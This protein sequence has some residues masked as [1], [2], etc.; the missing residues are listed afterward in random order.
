GPAA[1]A[2]GAALARAGA[3]DVDAVGAQDV[4]RRRSGAALL[5]GAGREILAAAAAAVREIRG[6]DGTEEA[7]H[8]TLRGTGADVVEAWRVVVALVRLAA[9]HANP[10]AVGAA[11][12]RI[13]VVARV[14]D[15]LVA[16]R[17]LERGDSAAELI[18]L[19]FG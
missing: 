11:F 12:L 14:V 18:G 15:A 8:L 3:A 16:G 10:A 4:R 2:A 5:R 19:Y 9:A 17:A 7:D 1:G 6:V 13:A